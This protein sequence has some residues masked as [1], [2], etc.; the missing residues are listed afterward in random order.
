MLKKTIYIIGLASIIS[1]M[2]VGCGKSKASHQSDKPYGAG[3]ISKKVS[4]E[5]ASDA[6]SSSD[7]KGT[8]A[9]NS[10]NL[11][12]K[13]Y[14]VLALE[15][16]FSQESDKKA[17]TDYFKD[18]TSV[19]KL[20]SKNSTSMGGLFYA[21]K[22]NSL[23]ESNNHQYNQFTYN[24]DTTADTFFK[25]GTSTVSL[26]YKGKDPSGKLAMS[27]L[28]V[29]RKTVSKDYL[30]KTFYKTSAQREHVDN[31]VKSIPNE[32][33]WEKQQESSTRY[34]TDN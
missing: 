34:M 6:S 19:K 27:Q 2:L 17:S 4:S 15:Y 8:N 31:Y 18:F 30:V 12:D 33:D 23:E 22:S 26:Q 29:I 11:D 25:V 21:D 1:L 7:S 20:S 24:G 32:D 16:R 10:L 28:P 3:Q 9:A 14:G 13:T 5:S